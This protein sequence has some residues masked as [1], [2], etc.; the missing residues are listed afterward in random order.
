M[1]KLRGFRSTVKSGVTNSVKMALEFIE[2]DQ[3]D[4]AIATLKALEKVH[5]L[6]KLKDKL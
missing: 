1:A 5:G 3:I 6:N 2:D 4:L